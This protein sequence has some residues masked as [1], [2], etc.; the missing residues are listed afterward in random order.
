LSVPILFRFV[1]CSKTDICVSLACDD[2]LKGKWFPSSYGPSLYGKY[3]MKLTLTS[4]LQLDEDNN[5]FMSYI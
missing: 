1:S 5:S 2:V 4:F 3:E